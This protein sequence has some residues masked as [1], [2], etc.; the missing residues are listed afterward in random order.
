MKLWTQARTSGVYTSHCM[1]G[2]KDNFGSD[3]CFELFTH[4]TS[5]LGYKVVMLGRYNGQG[6]GNRY[7]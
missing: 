6:L 1:T 5:F 3:F 2:V 7:I 4:M